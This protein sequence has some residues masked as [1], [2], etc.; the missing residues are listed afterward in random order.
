[1]RLRQKAHLGFQA[2][3]TLAPAYLDYSNATSVNE[4]YD[5]V[6]L[7]QRYKGPGEQVPIVT[8]YLSRMPMNHM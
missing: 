6:Y 5:D 1:M 4:I 8:I 3:S 7:E 2:V